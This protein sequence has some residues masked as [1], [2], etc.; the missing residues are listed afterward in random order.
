MLRARDYEPPLLRGMR[1]C[2]ERRRT[3]FWTRAPNDRDK[4]GL[5]AYSGVSERDE[6]APRDDNDDD[7]GRVRRSR[8]SVA[9]AVVVVV[10]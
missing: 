7:D 1:P 2:R 8:R 6:R 4:L 10:A 9:A 5:E 3:A